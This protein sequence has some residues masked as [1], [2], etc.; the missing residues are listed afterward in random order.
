MVAVPP[1]SMSF[2]NLTVD[3]TV[4]NYPPLP[5][6]FKVD[7]VTGIYGHN[8]L[9][10]FDDRENKSHEIEIGRKSFIVELKEINILDVRGVVTPYEYVFGISE[11]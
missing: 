1:Y 3:P 4:Q 2:V 6:E 10:R 8:K 5:P 11:K 9:Y 7:G